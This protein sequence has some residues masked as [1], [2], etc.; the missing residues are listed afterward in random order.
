MAWQLERK[1]VP[2]ASELLRSTIIHSGSLWGHYRL[3][4]STSWIS[5]EDVTLALRFSAL[6]LWEQCARRGDADSSVACATRQWVPL[7]IVCSSRSGFAEQVWLFVL[8]CG[9]LR[10]FEL[11][12]IIKYHVGISD[13]KKSRTC[14]E[15]FW[16]DQGQVSVW[17]MNRIE[18]I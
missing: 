10:L 17:L 5:D 15:N 12:N 13:Q 18:R 7:S 16:T 2:A 1:L 8:V 9:C 14:L 6:Q 4:L 11:E 3:I